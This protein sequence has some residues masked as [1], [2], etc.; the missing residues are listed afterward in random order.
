VR[1]GGDWIA[2][3]Q[4]VMLLHEPGR[5]PVAYGVD[6]DLTPDEFAHGRQS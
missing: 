1:F 5:Y 3:S 2:D 4:D 6:R